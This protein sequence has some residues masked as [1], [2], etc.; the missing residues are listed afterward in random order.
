MLCG[1]PTVTETGRVSVC[2]DCGHVFVRR[3]NLERYNASK[4]AEEAERRG[5]VMACAGIPE[6]FRSVEPDAK[7]GAK[8]LDGR[9]FYLQGG[10]GT[11]K[12]LKA[13]SIAR[14][15]LDRGRTVRFIS[16]ASLMSEF[17]DTFD[18]FKTEAD[19]F[20]ALSGVDLLVIDDL[21]K[22]NPSSWAAT[23]LYTVIDGRYGACKPIVVTSN[24][25]KPELIVRL[26]GE[27]D[28]STARAIVSRLTEM[29]ETVSFTGRDARS[30]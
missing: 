14:A 16:S 4:R 26:K 29:T 7:M 27:A 18:G 22:E 25:S 20:D 6:R 11:Y 3:V 23:M 13:A 5:G 30:R 15:L 17:R 8:V 12:T 24:Y 9:G 10:N 19:I 1:G 2:Q 21:G 28:D